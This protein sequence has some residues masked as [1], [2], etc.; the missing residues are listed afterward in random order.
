MANIFDL[1]G[2]V[3]LINGG[4]GGLGSG[5]SLGISQAG[6]T[7]AHRVINSLGLVMP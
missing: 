4:A 1:S 6:A 7:V 5:L 2:K 3:A